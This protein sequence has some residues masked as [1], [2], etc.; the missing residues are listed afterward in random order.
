MNWFSKLFLLVFPHRDTKNSVAKKT[1]V[2][3]HDEFGAFEYSEQ[4]FTLRYRNFEK[5]VEWEDITQFNVYKVDLM[6]TDRIDMELICGESRF[7]INE[8]IPGWQQFIIKTKEVFPMIP[9]EWDVDIMFP[10]FATNYRTIYQ[11]EIVV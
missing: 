9:K 2:E 1:F 10:A 6:T 5:Q 7:A 8:E 4:V 11:K 3:L